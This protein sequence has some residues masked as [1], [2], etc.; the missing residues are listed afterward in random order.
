[1]RAASDFRRGKFF[2]VRWAARSVPA[3]TVTD[4]ELKANG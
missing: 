4:E 2:Y 3:E 1:V